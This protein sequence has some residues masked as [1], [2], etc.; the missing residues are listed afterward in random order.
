MLLSQLNLFFYCYCDDTQIYFI[1]TLNKLSMSISHIQNCYKIISDW[2]SKNFLKLNHNKTEAIIIGTENSVSK[3]KNLI[4]SIKLGDLDVIFSSNIKN[5][6]V[7]IDETLSFNSHIKSVSSSC[8]FQLHNL[9]RIR[10]H[11]SKSSLETVIHAFISTRLDYCNSLYTGLPDSTIRPL[12]IAQN[13]AARI[14]FQENK[15][16]H[17]TPLLKELHWLLIK[18]R[19]EYKALLFVYKSLN[20]LAP[21]YLSS[22]IS[23]Y[24]PNRSLRS[25]NNQSLVIPRSKKASMGDRAFSVF[26]PKAWQK[27]DCSVQNSSSL[28]IFKTSLKTYL[29]RKYFDNV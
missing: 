4:Q 29:F 18:A 25:S 22:L 7:N 3:C 26:A 24:K 21:S 5:L 10:S 23:Y 16:C 28:T 12:Q 2:L 13:Y 17:I 1:C 20:N 11:F 27:L 8:M 6:G 9:N 15:Y 14:L 19:I